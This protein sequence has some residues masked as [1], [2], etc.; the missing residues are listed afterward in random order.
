MKITKIFIDRHLSSCREAEM[1]VSRT[2]IEPDIIED[3]KEVFDYVN[4][5]DDPVLKGKQTLYITENQG[6]VIRKCPGT[7]YYTCCDYTILHTAAFCTMDCSYCILQAYFHPPV[8]LYFVGREKIERE[9][10]HIFCEKKIFRIGTGEFTDSLIWEKLTDLPVFLVKKFANQSNSILELK[11]KTVNIDSLKTICHNNKT[12]IAWSMNTPKV[13]K[14]EERST[15]SLD[16]RLEAAAKCESWGYRL[17]FHFDPVVIYDGCEKEYKE[18]VKRIFSHVSCKSIVWISIGTFRFM[19]ALKQIIEKRFPLSKIPY[20]EFVTGL[21]NKMRY[22]KPLRIEIYKKIISYIREYAPD[23]LV[24][25]CM[26][27]QEVWEKS[28]GFFPKEQG[29]LGLLLDES[30]RKH[31]DLNIR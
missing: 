11:T 18:V 21:D 13:I 17:A 29:E 25:F 1:L 6:S 2:G 12:I 27:D 22:F 28:L 31:C 4:S 14:S 24:Y 15:A 20:G 30:A 10:D 3:S 19:P 5:S 16:A 26:E 7:S 23:V 8:L 9:L